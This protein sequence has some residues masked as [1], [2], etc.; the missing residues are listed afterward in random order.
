MNTVGAQASGPQ[1]HKCSGDELHITARLNTM[2]CN[3]LHSLR[4]TSHRDVHSNTQPN[5][6]PTT[7]RHNYKA[8]IGFPACN[9]NHLEQQ[10]RYFLWLML[11]ILDHTAF[12]F[13]APPPDTRASPSGSVSNLGAR[14]HTSWPNSRSIRCHSILAAAL[15]KRTHFGVTNRTAYI[16]GVTPSPCR[17]VDSARALVPSKRACQRRHASAAPKSTTTPQQIPFTHRPPSPSSP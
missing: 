10:H 6:S 15:A 9:T 17:P 14:A 13:T 2:Q 1:G 5:H 8:C 4:Q 16:T 3:W 12:I 11:R 7:S